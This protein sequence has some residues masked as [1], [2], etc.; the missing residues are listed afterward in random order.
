MNEEIYT[1]DQSKKS[2]NAKRI[3]PENKTTENRYG[4]KL[5]NE[6]SAGESY[7]KKL[8]YGKKDNS[9]TLE[10][11]KKLQKMKKQGRKKIYKDKAVVDTMRKAGIQN[12]DDNV[13]TETLDHALGMAINSGVRVR[14]HAQDKKRANYAKKL[15]ARNKHLDE[16]QGAKD[17]WDV[18]VF[19]DKKL[20]LKKSF[21]RFLNAQNEYRVIRNEEEQTDNHSDIETKEYISR[22]EAATL[23]GVTKSTI[24]KWMQAEKFVCVGAGKVLRIH[25]DDFLQ[26][27]NENMKGVR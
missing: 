7:R 21:Q 3:E 24:T 23:A 14:K 11:K 13:G 4:T 15:H 16:V 6:T 10:E 17:I 19:N 8:R 25:R 27:L 12:E 26:W 22:E 2:T 18:I 20:I 5:K 9:L 1:R